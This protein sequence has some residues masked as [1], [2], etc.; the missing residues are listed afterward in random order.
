M[1]GI[2]KFDIQ[3]RESCIL[4]PLDLF[5]IFHLLFGMNDPILCMKTVKLCDLVFLI[6]L[7]RQQ[8]S[9]TGIQII[10]QF[11]GAVLLII[12]DPDGGKGVDQIPDIFITFAFACDHKH[13]IILSLFLRLRCSQVESAYS[14]DYIL[15]GKLRSLHRLKPC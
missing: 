6:I 8:T 12:S 1:S 5:Q 10:P 3:F 13:I 9:F 4:F 11:S 7:Q 14:L 15:R 2:R